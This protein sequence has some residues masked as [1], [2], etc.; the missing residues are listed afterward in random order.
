MLSFT[1]P[2][3]GPGTRLTYRIRVIEPAA[4]APRILAS[5]AVSGPLDTDMR[6]TLRSDSVEVEA[7]FQVT[8]I[9]DTVNLGAEFFTRRRVGRSRRGLPVWEDDTYRRVVR[10]AWND[11]ARGYPFG[12]GRRDTAP[13]KRPWVWLSPERAFASGEA[14]PAE[15]F[16]VVD[17]T[18]DFRL[19][20][21][22]RPPR[23]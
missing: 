9:G 23:G 6:L 11:T 21:G 19:E 3:Q 10:L 4:V 22:V 16:D 5:G 2:T 14:R 13:R 18:R 20:A 15:E 7:L 8:P 1:I 12:S 17:T